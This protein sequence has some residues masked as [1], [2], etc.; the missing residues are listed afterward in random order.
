MTRKYASAESDP[1]QAGRDLRVAN[2]V[3][4]HYIKQGDKLMVTVEAIDVKSNRVFWQSTVTASAQ[5]L[6]S[7]QDQIA[8]YVRQGLLPLLGPPTGTL[9]AATRPQNPE[10]YDLYLRSVSVPHD[11]APN[12]EAI[13][14]LERAVGLDASFAPAWSELGRRYY[15]DASYSGGGQAIMQRSDAAYE[16]ALALD[17][18]FITAAAYLTQNG[19]EDGE[20]NKAYDEAQALVKRRS[21]SADAHFTL[22]YVLRYA[23]L[24]RDASVSAMPP[25]L[26]I[27]AISPFAPV[28]SPFLRRGQTSVPWSI[29]DS[30]RQRIM[31]KVFIEKS[32]PNAAAC[33]L[34][35]GGQSRCLPATLG[36]S[37]IGKTRFWFA[38]AADGRVGSMMEK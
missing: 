11:P 36:S 28:P 9:Q 30:G 19:V 20:L 1:Q 23:G 22:A 25:C 27:L 35:S 10:A 26:W 15:Y 17:P 14:M 3:A 37:M 2:V 31:R 16:R 5:D 24:L 6:I 4:G 12:K 21:D 32:S 38:H 7:L 13:T 33:D 8:S 34:K 18:N 29:C